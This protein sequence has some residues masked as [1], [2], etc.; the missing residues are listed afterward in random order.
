MDPA[1][2]ES[3]EKAF[4]DRVGSCRGDCACGKVY[5]DDSVHGGWDWEEG[6]LDKLRAN[7]KAVAIAEGVGFLTFEGRT[8]VFQ[9][10]CWRERA[11]KVG[12]WI[13]A[14][15]DS[16]ATFLSEEKKRRERAAAHFPTVTP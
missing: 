12:A 13:L 5:F 11:L 9:C 2:W 10:D 4:D 3:F 6:E 16:I 1:W 14:H 15:A 7:P 8:F